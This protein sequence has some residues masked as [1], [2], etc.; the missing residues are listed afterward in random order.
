VRG[1]GGRQTRPVPAIPCR[2]ARAGGPSAPGVE[3]PDPAPALL[4]LV[5]GRRPPPCGGYPPARYRTIP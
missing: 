1:P 2:R 4:A 3:R 5:A